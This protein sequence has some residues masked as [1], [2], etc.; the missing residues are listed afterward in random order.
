ML[1]GDNQGAIAL[2][3]NAVFHNRSKHIDIQYHYVRDELEAGTIT[4][5]YIH[6]SEM[7]ADALTK[8]LAPTHHA[9]AIRSIGMLAPLTDPALA[10]TL[11][12]DR[13][14]RALHPFGRHA[15]TSAKGQLEA[16]DGGP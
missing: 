12:R 9:Q 6:T 4:L 14:A 8:S 5:Q 15:P 10:R 11:D 2:S 3:R 1:Y 13:R 16:I 7:L